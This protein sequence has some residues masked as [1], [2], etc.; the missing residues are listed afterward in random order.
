[1][2]LYKYCTIYGFDILL[3][4]RIKASR[5]QD[6]NDPFEIM[7]GLQVDTALDSI[8]N[9]YKENPNIIHLWCRILDDQAIEYDK[10]SVEDILHKITLFQMNDFEKSSQ[11]LREYWNDKMGIICLSESPY[12]IQ[13]WAHYTENHQGIVIGIEE[14]EFVT[15][16]ETIVEVEYKDEMI[17]LPVTGN[18]DNL[19][20]YEEYILDV[21]KRKQ[22]EWRYEREYRI[23]VHLDEK[24]PD[25]NY[26]F[27]IPPSSIREI[28]IGLR[29]NEIATLIAQSIRQ[30]EEYNHLMIYKMTRHKE[31][32]K[33]TPQEV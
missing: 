1:M 32:Y 23:Y 14:T 9:G 8:R 22:T 28:Y 4:S 5:I 6:F 27:N 7:F 12:I 24:D 26:Y 10:S 20:K 31:K 3:R 15:D 29:S 2:L 21:L 13:M 19:K 18:P 16:R 11:I 17:L 25:G 30:R 33:L